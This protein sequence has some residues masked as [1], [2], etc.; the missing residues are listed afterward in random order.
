MAG[1]SQA[2]RR[3][4]AGSSQASLGA[5]FGLDGEQPL[6]PRRGERLGSD[7]G[8]EVHDARVEGGMAIGVSRVVRAA[9]GAL[10][11]ARELAFVVGD[12]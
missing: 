4:I 11:T 5:R 6:P 1:S 3:P 9:V 10:P 2:H 7:G 8:A 12:M